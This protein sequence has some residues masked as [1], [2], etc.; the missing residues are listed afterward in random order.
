MR[1]VFTILATANLKT[2]DVSAASVE[3]EATVFQSANALN[4]ACYRSKVANAKLPQAVASLTVLVTKKEEYASPVA[5]NVSKKKNAAPIAV[6]IT[7]L[8]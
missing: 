8:H 6:K 3:N 2:S 1:S 5:V 4:S 7:S